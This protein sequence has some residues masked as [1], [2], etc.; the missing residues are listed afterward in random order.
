MKIIQ[1]EKQNPTIF[2]KSPSKYL[3]QQSQQRFTSYTPHQN[4]NT[5]RVV[6]YDQNIQL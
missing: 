6:D 4:K 5:S 3:P 1:L 2:M